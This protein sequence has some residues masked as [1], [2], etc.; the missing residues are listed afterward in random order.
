[1]RKKY[2]L[3]GSGLL[4]LS[5]LVWMLVASSPAGVTLVV[6]KLLGVPDSK[7]INYLVLGLSEL[8]LIVPLI[9]YM[10]ITKT[11]VKALMGNRTSPVQLLLA[12]AIG[13]LLAPAIQGVTE[14]F[15]QICIALGAKMPDESMITPDSIGTMLV[16]MVAIGATAGIVEEPIF[17]GVQLRGLGSVSSKHTAVWLSA[18]VFSFIHMDIVGAPTRLL[19]GALLGYMAWRSGAILPGVIAHATYNS[20]AVGMSLLFTTSLKSWDGFTLPNASDAI[21]SIFTANIISIPFLVLLAGAY[22]FF[23]RVTPAAAAWAPQPYDKASAGSFV[24]WLPWIGV[25]LAALVL[26]AVMSYITMWF[27]MNQLL[28]S[29]NQMT[30]QM[31]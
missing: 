1:M 7:Y 20:T 27:D 28:E 31:K 14:V 5:F 12:A 21:N 4:G 19:I 22:W 8:L 18:F 16:G 15:A 2:T 11:S 29:L 26:T 6:L 23:A 24:R 3:L 30:E 17:R 9:V 25:G 13:I 10:A